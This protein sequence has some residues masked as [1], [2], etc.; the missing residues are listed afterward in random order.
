MSALPNGRVNSTLRAALHLLAFAA[1]I[2]LALWRLHPPVMTD[3]V[4]AA[5]VDRVLATVAAEPH[6]AGSE[7]NDRVRGFLADE[8]RNLGYDVRI[9]EGELPHWF[10][11]NRIVAIGNIVATLEG[12]ESTGD[13]L[14]LV[15]HFD[16]AG[17]ASHGAGDAGA[18]VAGVMEAARQFAADPPR[19]DVVILLTDAEEAGLLGAQLWARTTAPDF[20]NARAVLNFE[21]RG[22]SGPA[23]LFETSPGDGW[24]IA[25]YTAASRYPVG[26][27]LAPAVYALLPNNTDFTVFIDERVDLPGLNYAFVGGYHNY[28]QPG[29]RIENLSR[30]TLF[31]TVAEAVAV[32]RQLGDAHL[33]DARADHDAI[34]FDVVSLAVVRY[35]EWVRWPILGLVI[36]IAAFGI[37][38]LERASFWRWSISVGI[39][40]GG[41]IAL[42][43]SVQLV[44]RFLSHPEAGGQFA[45]V[46][47]GIFVTA[48]SAG[49]AVPASPP[50]RARML[51][52][53]TVIFALLSIASAIWLPGASYLPAA[54]TLAGGIVLWTNRDYLWPLGLVVATI[55]S[56]MLVQIAWLAGQAL[57]LELAGV[58]AAVLGATVL[59]WL[60]GTSGIGFRAG[61]EPRP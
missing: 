49:L 59:L 17:R 45:V 51:G 3:D 20:M 38:E 21:G 1:A 22:T 5:Y 39:A 44:A 18:G 57:T 55:V 28:H 53:A 2:A 16:S 42:V 10:F 26:T 11:R 35:P 15:S 36:L 6:P 40:L 48:I 33:A 24:L 61:G 8:L 12:S 52:A 50:G 56:A 54:M 14:L 9:Q 43:A 34:F 7:A 58:I 41:F 47:A 4:D 60:P 19:N 27:S 32:S 23:V 31:H 25:Q 29:D 37:S 13:A 46:F 30:V